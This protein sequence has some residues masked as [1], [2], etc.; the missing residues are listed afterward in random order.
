MPILDAV[1]RYVEVYRYPALLVLVSSPK[2]EANRSAHRDPI[3]CGLNLSR[4]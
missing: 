3:N 2:V 1:S 4:I